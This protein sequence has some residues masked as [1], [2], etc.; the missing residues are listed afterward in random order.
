M[1]TKISVAFRLLIV[2]FDS[3][4]SRP[5]PGVHMDL[6]DGPDRRADFRGQDV[7]IE[8]MHLC[9]LALGTAWKSG[10]ARSSVGRVFDIVRAK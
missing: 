9:R 1:M 5:R 10:A 3:A 4:W 2:S 8:G 6:G 7:R